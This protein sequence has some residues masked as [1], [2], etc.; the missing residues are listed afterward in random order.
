VIA[1]LLVLVGLVVFVACCLG[2][3]AFAAL[4]RRSKRAKGEVNSRRRDDE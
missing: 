3:A 4:E 1:K 2:C